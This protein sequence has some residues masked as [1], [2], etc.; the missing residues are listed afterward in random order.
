MH[1]RCTSP[2]VAAIFDAR[3]NGRLALLQLIIII[4]NCNNAIINIIG[5]IFQFDSQ[6]G[7][8]H[9]VGNHY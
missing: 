9:T 7:L 8:L 3:M 6:Q 1:S 4:I 2:D 5:L